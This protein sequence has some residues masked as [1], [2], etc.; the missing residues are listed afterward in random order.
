MIAGLIQTMLVRSQY[1]IDMTNLLDITDRVI[2]AMG[3]TSG[4]GRAIAIGLARHGAIVVPSGRR[5]EQLS[6]LCAEIDAT[7][8]RTLCQTSDVRD[9]DSIDR[10]RDAVFEKFGRVDVLVNAAGVTFKEPTV[11]VSE[12]Q[13]TALM[14]TD[15]TGVLRACQSFYAPL[16]SSGRGR[17]INIASLGSFLGFY[18]V[19]A[20]AAA[21][22]AVLSLTRSLGCEWANDGICV[23]AIV[24]GVFPTELNSKLIMGTPR[25]NEILMRT[26]MSRFGKPEELIGVAILLA[27]DGASFLTGQSIAV[28]GGYLAS[29]VNQ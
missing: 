14:D 6:A 18:Q 11:Q 19:A 24:P 3:A 23:N 4:L 8:N 9:R 5:D 13:W 7:G 20:Y 25:G 28:D 12:Q 17:I 10:L 27:S 16:K 29:G 15:L 26:P 2:V 21:K 1:L 22:T